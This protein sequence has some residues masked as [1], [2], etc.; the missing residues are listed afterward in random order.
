MMGITST[1]DIAGKESS[2]AVDPNTAEKL[3]YIPRL[4]NSE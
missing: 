2:Y 1:P 4:H 3:T